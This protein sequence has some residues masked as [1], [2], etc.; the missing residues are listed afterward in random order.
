[1]K[2]SN[3]LFFFLTPKGRDLTEIGERGVNISGGQKQRIS[4]ARAVYSNADLYIF[5]D[6]LSALDSRVARQVLVPFSMSKNYSQFQSSYGLFFQVF[7]NCIKE[8]LQG[9]TRLLVTNQLHFLPQVDRVIVISDGM[10]QEE[11]TYEELSKN[12]KLFQKLMENAGKMEQNEKC[13]EKGSMSASN[14]VV[15][16]TFDDASKSENG[17][18]GA[19]GLIKEEERETG[20]IS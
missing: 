5:D 4:M 3:N 12:G 10:V 19:S 17:K 8:E 2:Y 9:K 13:I 6:P 18:S 11:G 14:G 7:N 16:E 20:V 15:N 1:M